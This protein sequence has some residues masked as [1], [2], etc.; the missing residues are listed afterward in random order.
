MKKNIFKILGLVLLLSMV[1]GIV[2]ISL[3]GENDRA[4]MTVKMYFEN[5]ASQRYEANTH[6]CSDTY[7]RQFDNVN[8][9]ITHQFS[10]ET[11][12]LNHFNLINTAHYTVEAQ[13]DEFWYPY[14]GTNTLHIS[15]RVR[16]QGS[17]NI[18]TNLMSNDDGIF[19]TDLVTLV[20]EDGKWKITNINTRSSSIAKDYQETKNSMQNSKYI[21]QTPDG[22]TVKENTIKFTT[23]DPIQK[24]II[25]FNLNKALTLLNNHK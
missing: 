12:L 3:L 8:D 20:R 24:R 18:L 16:P 2:L 6:L 4:S 13:R 14:L 5:I 1:I 19:L 10:L 21:Q 9:P 15:I 25:N 22:L 23:L 11:A 7:N 17:G